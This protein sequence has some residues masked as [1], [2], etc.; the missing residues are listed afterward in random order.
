MK[1]NVA[2]FALAMLC[3]AALPALA[4]DKAGCTDDPLF[5]TRMPNYRI[6]KCET[7]EYDF[8]DFFT[9]KPPKKR[10]EGEVTKITYAVSKKE[11][12]RGAIE[13]VRNYEN[14]IKKIGG[15]IH[16]PM[17][18]GPTAIIG[19]VLRE[20]DGCL[21][22]ENESGVDLPLWPPGTVVALL[23]TTGT[24][25]SGT[26]EQPA[27]TTATARARKIRLIIQLPP[28]GKVISGTDPSPARGYRRP[29]PRGGP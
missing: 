28:V 11:D 12:A 13:I 26:L 1:S 4:Q 17:F 2:L 27:I 25:L 6:E 3:L 14:A 23:S 10:V 16:K 15:T 7:K 18:G 22:F 8:H 19:G 5:P 24:S 21:V 20:R 29:C 9:A